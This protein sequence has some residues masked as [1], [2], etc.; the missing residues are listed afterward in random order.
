MLQVLTSFNNRAALRLWKWIPW[1]ISGRSLRHTKYTWKNC[2][3]LTPPATLSWTL[4]TMQSC[5]SADY[6][7][8]RNRT[9]NWAHVVL[10]KGQRQDLELVLP[11]KWKDFVKR[12]KKRKCLKRAQFLQPSFF[13][14][15]LFALFY[16]QPLVLQYVCPIMFHLR[17]SQLSNAGARHWL[18]SSWPLP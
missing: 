6:I 15:F 12:K 10:W 9:E 18:L 13:W 2:C 1:C 5:L 8:R 16:L 14:M 7:T 4:T 11:Y 17:A 3:V